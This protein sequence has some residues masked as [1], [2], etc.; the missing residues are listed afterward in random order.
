[1][2]ID[3]NDGNKKCFKLYRKVKN[4]LV[5]Q[6]DRGAHYRRTGWIMLL[7]KIEE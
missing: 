2:S 7:R 4:P 1:M 6:S 5:L 3:Q